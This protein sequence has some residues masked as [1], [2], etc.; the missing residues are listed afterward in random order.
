MI[1]V[2]LCAA[3]AAILAG[4]IM[5]QTPSGDHYAQEHA[6]AGN[7]EKVPGPA[8]DNNEE[9]PTVPS[10][11]EGTVRACFLSIYFLEY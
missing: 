6:A 3:A 1:T 7:D 4:S 8:H 11:Q 10:G 2:I 5:L 9:A